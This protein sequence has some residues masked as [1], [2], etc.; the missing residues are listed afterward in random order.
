MVPQFYSRAEGCRLWDLEG[1]E[2]IDF[3]CGYGPNILGY[4]DQVNILSREYIDSLCGY[5]LNILG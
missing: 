4:G 3:L 5:G 2:Y 1:R